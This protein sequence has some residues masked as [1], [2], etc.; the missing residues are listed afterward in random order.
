[1]QVGGLVGRELGVRNGLRVL[2]LLV[3]PQHPA[4]GHMRLVVYLDGDIIVDVD[5][6]IGWVHRT[7]EKLSEVKGWVRSIPLLERM[8]IV[9]ACNIILG[10]VEA[11]E[12]LMGL[13]PPERVKYLRT[14]LCEI[15]RI[16]SHLY[17]MGIAG[18]FL[19]HSTMFMWAMGDREVWLRLIEMITGTRLTHSYVIPGGVRRDIPKSF[20]DVFEKAAKYQLKRLEEYRKIFLDNPVIRD[21]Y[22]NVGVLPKS[23]ASRL[24]IVGPNLRASGIAYDARMLGYEAYADLDFEPVVLDEGDALA[25]MKARIEEIKASIELV[26]K[27]LKRLPEGK[28]MAEKFYRMVPPAA[29]KFIDEGVAK[30]PAIFANL[31]VPKGEVVT[32]VEAGRG[33]ILYH[34]VSDGG[35]APYRAR[36]VTPSFRNAILLR[37]LAIGERLMDLPAIYGSLDYFPPEAD[38]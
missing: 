16:A 20:Q 32:R 31:R 1:M 3:G 21:R 29:R 27:A 5:V 10:Y 19:N 28:I 2:E 36:V 25:R 9:D 38:K 24:G 22:E 26:R 11:I 12:K 18:I 17:G 14:I 35:L 4:S 8:N 7:M 30:F 37:E 34:I 13:E 6:D 23:M 33:E 15:N